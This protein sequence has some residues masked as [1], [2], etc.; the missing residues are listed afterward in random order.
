MPLGG[1]GSPA[2]P[3]SAEDACTPVA[4]ITVGGAE[5]CATGD[6]A[7]YPDAEPKGP[8]AGAPEKE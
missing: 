2:D 8:E 3:R 6:T 1:C 7:P 5:T 4:H